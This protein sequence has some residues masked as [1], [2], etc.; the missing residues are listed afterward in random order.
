MKEIKFSEEYIEPSID[1]ARELYE[2]AKGVKEFI[3]KRLK[4]EGLRW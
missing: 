1:K 3:M 2:T 4:E